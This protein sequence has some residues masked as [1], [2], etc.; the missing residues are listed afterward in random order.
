MQGVK[1]MVRSGM[2]LRWLALAAGLWCGCGSNGDGNG[3]TNTRAVECVED[4]DWETDALSCMCKV[5]TNGCDEEGSCQI[6]SDA[7]Y[8]GQGNVLSCEG[9]ACCVRTAGECSCQGDAET[10][11]LR[12]G[13]L[14]GE[15]VA[16]CA[17]EAQPQ[18]C[19]AEGERC[20][21]F[22][23]V[24]QT[25]ACCAGTICVAD[26][27]G[28]ATCRTPEA[29]ERE[30]S[31]SCEQAYRHG[32]RVVV[33]QPVET[34]LGTFFGAARGD[35]REA[36]FSA[37]G[38]L[39]QVSLEID[40]DDCTLSLKAERSADG[41]FQVTYLFLDTT[42]CEGASEETIVLAEVKDG[43]SIPAT[44]ETDLLT[45]SASVSADEYCA[46]GKLTVRFDGPVVEADAIGEPVPLAFEK[47]LELEVALCGQGDSDLSCP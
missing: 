33:T 17:S 14:G 10:C 46:A 8:P 39:G 32:D 42:D 13:E 23:D 21:P 47:A 20:Q 19:A 41:T 12:A 45:C 34:S 38:C 44:I 5:P 31:Q 27:S 2:R 29:G 25:N 7:F 1:T 40:D 16:S 4:S 9:Y 30:Q 35:A 3:K 43:D 37:T 18:R 24:E 36:K 11:E 28:I 15:V 22:H 26:D 6:G